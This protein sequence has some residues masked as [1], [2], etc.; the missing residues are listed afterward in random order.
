VLGSARDLAI[1]HFLGGGALQICRPQE[2]AAARTGGSCASSI[3]ASTRSRSCIAYTVPSEPLAAMGF[4]NTV[5]RSKRV[6]MYLLGGKGRDPTGYCILR[7]IWVFVLGSIWFL[8][9][10]YSLS[11]FGYL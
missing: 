8:G 7:L 9:T 10:C 11:S 2:I 6:P 1:S 3:I 4:Q 5:G